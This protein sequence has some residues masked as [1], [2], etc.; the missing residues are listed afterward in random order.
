MALLANTAWLDEDLATFQYLVV[1][2][3]DEQVRVAQV[4]PDGLSPGETSDFCDCV[5]WHDSSWRWLRRRRLGRVV[6]PLRDLGVDV[7]HALDGRL[8]EGALRL[9]RQLWTPVVLGTCSA[10]DVAQVQRLRRLDEL[11][12]VVFVATT[13]PLAVAIRERLPADAQVEIVPQGVHVP[14]K[15]AA[16]HGGAALCAAVTG[17]GTYDAQYDALMVAMQSIVAKY[18]QAQFFFDGQGS[19]QHLLWQAAKRYGL[20]SHMSLVP[21]RLGHR[22]LL[23]RADVLIHP[24]SLGRSR[25]LTLQAMAHGVP[26]MAMKDPWLDYL[27]HDQTAWVVDQADPDVW[28]Q[29]I[30]RFVETPSLGRDLAVQAR[31]WVR[32]R[33]R[34]AGQVGHTLGL[35]RQITGESIKFPSGSPGG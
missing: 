21:R 6:D 25:T 20:L 34:A 30:D 18:P 7:V 8:W 2:L 3:I 28:A 11:V 32:R 27:I 5:R 14:A 19:D 12:K 17:N 31:R 1:G 4:V 24:Q 9:A 29:M 35:Y 26:V 16:I 10:L 15:S 22:E 23:L 13:R 33:H